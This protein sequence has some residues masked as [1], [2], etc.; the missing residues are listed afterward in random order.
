MRRPRRQAINLRPDHAVEEI[1]C[2]SGKV[3][4]TRHHVARWQLRVDTTAAKGGHPIR[5]QW[6]I[7]LAAIEPK[8]NVRQGRTVFRGNGPG[9]NCL[10]YN[11]LGWDGLGRE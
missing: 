8:R 10:G 2:L 6:R 9:Y 3:E 11:G 7:G 5:R 4:R 1:A